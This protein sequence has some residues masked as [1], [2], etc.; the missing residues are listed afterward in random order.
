M[1]DHQGKLF[2]SFKIVPKTDFK[3]M[4]AFYSNSAENGNVWDCKKY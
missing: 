4:L 1:L 3:K 2:W